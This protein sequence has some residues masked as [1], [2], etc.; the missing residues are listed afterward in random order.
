M[1]EGETAE[2]LFNFMLVYLTVSRQACK[3]ILEK[4][5]IVQR[6]AIPDVLVRASNSR[7]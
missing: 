2:L 5:K 1:R 4:P 3:N 6:C 7:I